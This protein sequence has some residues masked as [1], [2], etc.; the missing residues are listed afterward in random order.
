MSIKFDIFDPL[1]RASV[2]K[3]L[4]GLQQTTTE[5]AHLF[6]TVSN[7]YTA[8]A[9]AHTQAIT[10]AILSPGDVILYFSYSGS[11]LDM[12]D[13]LRIAR[14]RGG[15]VILITRFPKSPG[16]ELADVVLQCGANESPLQLGSVAARIAQMF[17]IDVLFTELCRRNPEECRDC[18]SRIAD[19]LAS[20]H[21]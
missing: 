15:K 11:T 20:K 10:A 8:V 3:K 21:I 6:S 4:T 13:T 17:L 1:L 2:T 16:G 9:D 14:E 18:R 12:L 5:A 19:A 7:K